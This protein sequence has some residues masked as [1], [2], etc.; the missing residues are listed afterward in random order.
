ME[1]LR[2][3]MEIARNFAPERSPSDKYN[4]HETASV[5]EGVDDEVNLGADYVPMVKPGSKKTSKK[6]KAEP[7]T[8]KAENSLINTLWFY[9]NSDAS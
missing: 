7:S 6:K 8:D 4:T 9:N 2:Q 1:L 3:L 5:I